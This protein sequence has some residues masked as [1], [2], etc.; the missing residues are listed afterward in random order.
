M[1]PFLLFLSVVF[2]G[3]FLRAAGAESM[4]RQ[5]FRFILDTPHGSLSGIMVLASGQGEV[6]GSMFNEF[7]LSAIDFRYCRRSRRVKLVNVI[8]FLDKWR[9]RYVLRRDLTA[10]VELIGNPDVRLGKHYEVTRD[11]DTFILSN[12]RRHMV[13]TLT[14]FC[15]EP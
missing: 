10:I 7:G 11:G 8:D 9:V 1:R 15:S 12:R 6:I 3:L 2:A 14:P 5:Q 13:Y 4:E